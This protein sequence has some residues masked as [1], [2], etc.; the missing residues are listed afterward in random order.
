MKSFLI[1]THTDTLHKPLKLGENGYSC[2]TKF[3]KMEK[4]KKVNKASSDFVWNRLHETGYFK[5]GKH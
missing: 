5:S 2:E 4:L 3:K 1:N